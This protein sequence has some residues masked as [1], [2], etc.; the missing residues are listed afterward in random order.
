LIAAMPN[1]CG[2]PPKEKRHLFTG[3]FLRCG[4]CG[5]A[6]VPRTRPESGYEFYECN[7]RKLHECKTGAIRRADIDEAVLAHFEQTVLDVEATREQI[8]AAV[9]RKVA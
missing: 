3:G 7:G 4:A 1:K 8:V 6:M 5:D 2:R 9:E